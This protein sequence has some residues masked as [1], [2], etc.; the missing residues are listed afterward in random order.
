MKQKKRGR[1]RGEGGGRGRESRR[2]CRV[3]SMHPPAYQLPW[4]QYSRTRPSGIT[5]L[6]SLAGREEKGRE[7]REGR[8]A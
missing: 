1:E 6:A 8:R 7:R 3:T 4:Q 5:W 2:D